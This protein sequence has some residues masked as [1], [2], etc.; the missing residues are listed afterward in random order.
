M[1][2]AVLAHEKENGRSEKTKL[3]E[4]SDNHET[5]EIDVALRREAGD[6]R[7]RKELFSSRYRGLKT[8]PLL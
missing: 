4:R 5:F 2:F 3:N 6:W 7:R 1:V 8:T